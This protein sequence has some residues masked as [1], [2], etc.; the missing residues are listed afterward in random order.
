MLPSSILFIFGGFYKSS[1][2]LLIADVSLYKRGL[3]YYSATLGGVSCFASFGDG[4]G[5]A[6]STY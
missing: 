3:T 5:S 6:K 4:A 2:F 1:F